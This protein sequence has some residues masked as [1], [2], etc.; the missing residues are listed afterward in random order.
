MEYMDL[1][2]PASF[3]RARLAGP[4]LPTNCAALRTRAVTHRVKAPVHRTTWSVF[5]YI[6]LGMEVGEGG[7]RVQKKVNK[8]KPTCR[9]D[10]IICLIEGIGNEK[11]F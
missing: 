10:E 8:R 5:V 6:K 11:V 2:P 9:D 7:K 1:L 3:S 4:N